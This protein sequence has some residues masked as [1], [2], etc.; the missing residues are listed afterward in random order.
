MYCQHCGSPLQNDVCPSCNPAPVPQSK[1]SKLPSGILSTVIS[2]PALA[3]LFVV[4]VIPTFIVLLLS[5]KKYSAMAGLVRSPWIGFE[6]FSVLLSSPHFL[7]I[8]K[9]SFLIGLF[10]VLLGSGMVFGATYGIACLKNKWIRRVVLCALILPSV[11]PIFGI[12]ASIIPKYWLTNAPFY[13]LAP[14]LYEMV[15]VAPLAVLA[16]S[17]SSKKRAPLSLALFVTIGYA[18][19]RL[20]SFFTLGSEFISAT[21][22]PLVYETADVFGTYT[23]RTGMQNGNLPV[24]AAITIIRMLLGLI[25]AAIGVAL[26]LFATQKDNKFPPVETIRHSITKS[27]PA[28]ILAAIMFILALIVVVRS[29]LGQPIF[30]NLS[31]WRSIFIGI[32]TGAIG[33]ILIALLGTLLSAPLITENR[34][35][36]VGG[37]IIF[38]LL[39]G[40]M[41]NR[42]GQYFF[43]RSMGGINTIAAVVLSYLKYALYFA[44]GLFIA[45]AG[46]EKK[47][48][49]KQIR[50]IGAPALAL[51]GVSFARL[52]G[53]CYTEPMLYLNNRSLYPVSLLLQQITMGNAPYGFFITLIVPV[54]ISFAGIWLSGLIE[55]KE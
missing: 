51:L 7:G 38:A 52:Y 27:L 19:L 48:F 31:V 11:L 29:L 12:C 17:F 33:S 36:Q 42:T 41:D 16:G 18:A 10:S 49:L 23:F 14:I 30:T 40:C 5:F 39:V 6:N 32:L 28:F 54:L 20:M 4:L 34:M 47:T 15:C 43:F 22:N 55:E 45:C 37:I 2:F 25:P 9:N 46:N 21:Y 13:P 8:F 35:V 24:S 50:S 44:F 26:L 1:K 53:T 3:I